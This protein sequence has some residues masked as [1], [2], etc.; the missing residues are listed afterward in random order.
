MD[1]ELYRN[2]IV[3]NNM[4]TTLLHHG[5]FIQALE[6]LRHAVETMNA[7]CY[8]LEKDVSSQ[9][10]LVQRSRTRVETAQSLVS[11]PPHDSSNNTLLVQSIVVQI[12]PWE[13]LDLSKIV[14]LVPDALGCEC[15]VAFSMDIELEISLRDPE[16]DSSLVI[17]NY[18]VAHLALARLGSA[19]VV[20]RDASSIFHLSLSILYT[21]FSTSVMQNISETE[22]SV[23]SIAGLSIAA[24]RN[25][26]HTLMNV[27]QESEATI[28][29]EKIAEILH[30]L[31]T[32]HQTESVFLR[33]LAAA[34]A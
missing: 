26:A 34:A 4:G 11:R 16:M 15:W 8:L 24:L 23:E 33:S 30:A 32:M 10:S 19:T 3:L 25:L 20:N 28:Y 17:Y 5:A 27:G 22:A 29:H 9:E 1:I 14:T 31:L 21:K 13:T 2:A 6:T 7:F 18:A 12:L